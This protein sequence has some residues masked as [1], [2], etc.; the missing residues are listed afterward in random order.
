MFQFKV[1]HNIILQL[2][3]LFWTL[4]KWNLEIIT[5]ARIFYIPQLVFWNDLEVGMSAE[6]CD[7]L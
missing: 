5:Q 2:S 6:T 3:I 4:Y 1:R 7:V